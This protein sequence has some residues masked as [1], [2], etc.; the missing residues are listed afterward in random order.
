MG[1]RGARTIRKPEDGTL[2]RHTS[3]PVMGDEVRDRAPGVLLSNRAL[4]GPDRREGNALARPL[5]HSRLFLIPLCLAALALAS[6][7]SGAPQPEPY[8]PFVAEYPPDGPGGTGELPTTP[9]PP[10]APQPP[11]FDADAYL[12]DRGILFGSFPSDVV[13]YGNTIFTTDGDQLTEEGA[14]IV[15]LDAAGSAPRPSTRFRP[16]PILAS[17]LIDS[18]GTAGDVHNP[19]GFGFFLNDLTVV[20]DRLGFVLVNAGGSDSTPALSNLVAFDPTGG[21]VLQVVDLVNPAAY[22]PGLFDSSGAPVPTTGFL[23][24][25]AEALA[26]ASS[27]TGTDRLYVAMTN[28]LFAAPSSGT[29]KYPGTVQTFDVVA[30][31][32]GPIRPR[33]VK[34]LV[35]E[36]WLTGG[37]NPVALAVIEADRL[38]WQPVIQRLLVTVAGAT[39]YD[40][41]WN[42]VPVTDASVAAF[43]TESGSLLGRFLLGKAGLSGTRPALG[44]DAAGHHVAFFPSAVTGEVYLLLLDGLYARSIDARRLAVLRGPENGIPIVPE[45][46]GGPG[47]NVTGVGLSPDGR[48]LVVAGFGD[49]FAFPEPKPGH[50]YLLGLPEDVVTGAEFGADFVPGWSLYGTVSGRALG[51]LT[52]VPNSGS[53]PDVYVAVSSPLDPATFLST[54][55]ASLGTLQ[56]FGMIE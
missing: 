31:Q 18:S 49:L 11:V 23:Q 9:P 7:G 19:V 17:D 26:Y 12:H 40:A 47:G 25:G 13:R 48:T 37:H 22:Q 28:L 42:L 2:S 44:E 15:P 43:D 30:G 52:L 55:P 45:A 53:R 24:S 56:T 16:V 51:A 5:A 38:P 54:G 1:R 41:S 20:N 4:G 50:L 36:T 21:T 33:P 27:S 10:E 14:W 29:V 3:T 6:C 32:A 39:G 34:G 46:A 35:T 8:Q